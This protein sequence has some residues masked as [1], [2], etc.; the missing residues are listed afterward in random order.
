[1][2]EYLYLNPIDNSIVTIFQS[3]NEPHVYSQDGVEYQRIFS[4]PQASFDTKIDPHDPN[5]FVK[6]T[7]NKK[8][9]VGSLW[10]KS[11]E[12]SEKRGGNSGVDPVKEQYYD[13]YSKKVGGK[14]H[15]DKVKESAKQKLDK[16]GVSVE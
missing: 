5:D 14:K 6:K 10:D 1:M 3:M 11:K 13:R 2:P 8:G 7:A 16:M 9:T 12:L 4:V 15:F